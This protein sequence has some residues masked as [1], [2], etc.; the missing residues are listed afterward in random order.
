MASG[1]S[2]YNPGVPHD[3][4][5]KEVLEH[6]LHDLQKFER[7]DKKYLRGYLPLHEARQQLQALA[8]DPE[9]YVELKEGQRLGH[10]LVIQ[11]IEDLEPN[12]MLTTAVRALNDFEQFV[13]NGRGIY[14]NRDAAIGHIELVLEDVPLHSIAELQRRFEQLKSMNPYPLFPKDGE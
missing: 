9:G 8:S 11:Y 10:D 1:P 14:P 6:A 13:M 12:M 7:G 5:R 2:A 4:H 3:L